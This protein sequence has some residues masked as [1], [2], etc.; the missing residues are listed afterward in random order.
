MG[1]RYIDYGGPTGQ[2][3]R[4][5]K[6]DRRGKV[7]INVT[8]HYKAGGNEENDSL[9][10]A[11]E[12]YSLLSSSSPERA[13]VHAVQLGDGSKLRKD[14]SPFLAFSDLGNSVIMDN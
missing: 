11:K 4:G 3:A 5:R 7:E 2:Q 6:R 13:G 8:K 14:E 12:D 9:M 1:G 10:S